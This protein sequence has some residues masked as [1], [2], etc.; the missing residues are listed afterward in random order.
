MHL[1]KNQ[2]RYNTE[3]SLLLHSSTHATM[4]LS[5]LE[6]D[7]FPQYI[8]CQMQYTKNTRMYQDFAVCKP[9]CFSGLTHNP[10]RIRRHTSYQ[11]S[12]WEHRRM[13]N[14]C[15]TSWDGCMSKRSTFKV[16]CYDKVLCPYCIHTACN[17]MY[18]VWA[19]TIHTK[20]KKRSIRFGT[21]PISSHGHHCIDI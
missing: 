1:K 19:A 17:C 8:V 5:M 20:S 7:L 14:H 9:A 6:E 13:T 18:I 15:T 12:S 10:L 21:Q 16:L 2:C 3:M 11:L 4:L